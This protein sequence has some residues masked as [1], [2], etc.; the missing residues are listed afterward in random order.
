[1]SVLQEERGRKMHA[2][3]PHKV[4]ESAVMANVNFWLK[5]S[6]YLAKTAHP[7]NS[8]QVILMEYCWDSQFRTCFIAVKEN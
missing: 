5:F 3:R 2:N 6:F 8:S 1:M 7:T 4:T